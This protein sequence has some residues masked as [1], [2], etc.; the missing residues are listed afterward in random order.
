LAWWQGRLAEEARA[1][2]AQREEARRM[3]LARYRRDRRRVREALAEAREVLV[4]MESCF[5]IIV[6]DF[7]LGMQAVDEPPAPP[8][9]S[10]AA[11]AAT[12]GK[13]KAPP[14]AGPPGGAEGEEDIVWEDV[15]E[16]RPIR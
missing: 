15:E 1:R 5:H 2:E 9:T 8:P 11:A 16:E 6:P 3:L 10:A 12:G 13:A 7:T 14:S 4:Q